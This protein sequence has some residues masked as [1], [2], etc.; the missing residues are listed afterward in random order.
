M[1]MIGTLPTDK[2]GCKGVFDSSMIDEK[3]TP[4]I[5]LICGHSICKCCFEK[6]SDPKSKESLVYCE[7]CQQETKNK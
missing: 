3:G 4:A 5:T 6:H 1:E 2:N 7:D